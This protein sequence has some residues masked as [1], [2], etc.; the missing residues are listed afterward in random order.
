M[1]DVEKANPDAHHSPAAEDYSTGPVL[2]TGW[3]YKSPKIAGKKIPWFASPEA[4]ITLVAFVCFMCPGE[5]SNIKC[6]HNVK[7]TI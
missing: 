1:A 3:R 4:Q 7:L 6:C 5:Y 2:P